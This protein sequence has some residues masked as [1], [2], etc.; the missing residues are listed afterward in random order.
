MKEAPPTTPQTPPPTTPLHRKLAEKI[1]VWRTTL[2]SPSPS[3]VLTWIKDGFLPEWADNPPAPFKI[4]Q[5]PIQP[6]HLEFLRTHLAELE[7]WGTIAP[8]AGRPLAVSPISVTTHNGAQRLVFNLR[9]LNSSLRPAPPFK[10]PAVA[11]AAGWT[12]SSSRLWAA[13]VRKMY[14]HI[15]VHPSFTPW[16]CFWHPFARTHYAFH[17]LPLG[18][19]QAPW[20]ATKILAPVVAQL[21]G[22]G[23]KIV[24]YMDDALGVSRQETA[25]TDYELY[26]KTLEAHGWALSTKKCTPPCTELTFLGF[27]LSTSPSPTISI[28]PRRR[29]RLL[30]HLRRLLRERRAHSPRVLAQ[31]LGELVACY[32]AAPSIRHHMAAPFAT[33]SSAVSKL[34]WR[35]R[36]PVQ[37]DE[38]ALVQLACIKRGLAAETTTST[39]FEPPPLAPSVILSTDAS[40]EFGWGAVLEQASGPSPSLL[41]ERQGSWRSPLLLPSIR[42][43][44]D[45]VERARQVPLP[46]EDRRVAEA[47]LP[48]DAD[49]TTIHGPHITAL[50]ATAV[51]F[52]MLSN[53]E[54]LQNQAVLIKTDA[55]TVVG[56]LTR[57]ASP[58]PTL[59]RISTLVHLVLRLSNARMAGVTHVAGI[60]N[61][62]PDFLSRNW[63]PLNKKLEWP[64]GRA[65]PTWI[66]RLSFHQRPPSS[67]I[68]A[69]ASSGN[70]VSRRFWSYGPDP[71]AEAQDGLVQSWSDKELWINPPFELMAKVARKLESDCPTRAIIISP[72]WPHRPWFH[73]LA[74]H[75][76]IVAAHELLPKDVLATGPT[77]N[78]AEPMRNPRWTL[79]AWVLDSTCSSPLRL[80]SQLRR[81]PWSTRGE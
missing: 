80:A 24:Q 37:L 71:M 2:P 35:S 10:M 40:T 18:L 42:E 46:A 11:D 76:N 26:C 68:D 33:L 14:Y 7:Q 70:A 63:L 28:L 54:A 1:D 25:Q 38:A 79:M 67:W 48:L 47:L 8:F 59:N 64:I 17:A 53:L 50:E 23:L 3:P 77:T 20:V 69:F 22:R 72:K 34:G 65:V 55:T 73:Q 13:D 62:R 36:S 57:R 5:P 29:V 60:E 58:S 81:P 75:P 15:P 43:T 44:I 4:H 21:T 27:Q 41:S 56:A 16:L 74:H 49:V 51:L 61:I 52:G 78:L 12:T 19:Q 45:R 66:W 39:P 30:A 6:N 32:A 31:T 9:R